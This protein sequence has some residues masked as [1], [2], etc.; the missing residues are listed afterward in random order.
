MAL[1]N[2]VMLGVFCLV[3]TLQGFGRFPL[4]QD[5]MGKVTAMDIETNCTKRSGLKF[6]G[7]RVSHPEMSTA[8]R[9]NPGRV[10]KFSAKI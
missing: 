7:Q 10:S 9:L 5:I 8:A 2:S 4:C 3:W 6:G 1:E